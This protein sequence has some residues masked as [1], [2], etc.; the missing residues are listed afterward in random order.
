MKY[1][2]CTVKDIERIFIPNFNDLF[3]PTQ[4]FGDIRDKLTNCF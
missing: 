1:L 4:K 2:I 3:V